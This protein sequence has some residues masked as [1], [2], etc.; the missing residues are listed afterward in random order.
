M[1]SVR[2]L[3]CLVKIWSFFS[4]LKIKHLSAYHLGIE[5]KT[6]FG[7]IKTLGKINDIKESDSKTF[8][9]LLINWAANTGFEHY[10]IS[11]LALN[12]SYS[13]HNSN[14]WSFRP[15]YWF[16]TFSSFLFQ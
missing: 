10:E 12:S 11:N 1:V 2:L 15:I 14:Y 8:F 6:Y 3:I 5:V 9:D 7:K 16:W 4:A 13:L